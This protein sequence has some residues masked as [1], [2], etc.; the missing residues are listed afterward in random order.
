MKTFS[1][2]LEAH[3]AQAVTTLAEGWRV[4]RQDATVWGWTNFN[5]DVTIDSVLYRS[6][7][8]LTPTSAHST[9]DLSVD[10]I[11]VSVFL[12]VSTELEIAAGLWDESRI[13]FFEYNWADPPATLTAED[14][15]HI[16]RAGTLGRIQRRNLILTA[17]I[18]GLAD[19]FQT[20]IGRQ[21]SPQCPWRHAIW[22]PDAGTY[23]ASVECQAD[24]AAASAIHDGSV[25]AVGTDA[26][27]MFS[28]SASTVPLSDYEANG[29][30]T[31]TSGP[32]AGISREVLTWDPP[33]FTMLRPWPYPLTVG[34]T[35]RAVRGDLRNL[36]TCKLIYS[37]L[38][39]FGGFPEVPGGDAVYVSP[40]GF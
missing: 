37:N 5:A 34:V 18:R 32:N 8:G 17:E 6:S 30:V 15:A 25:T 10:S 11:D 4:T 19:A 23:V 13:L 16:K 31:P 7:Q 38:V 22:S 36:A 33:D 35:Y 24:L 27:L 3:Y 14:G 2:A 21:Y 9:N 12:D 28:D 40:V 29:L 20:R 39:N 1:P 26:T